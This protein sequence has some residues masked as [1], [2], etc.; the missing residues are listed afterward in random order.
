MSNPHTVTIKEGYLKIAFLLSAAHYHPVV[1]DGRIEAN[2]TV[3]L[4]IL[5][6][7]LYIHCKTFCFTCA[8]IKIKTNKNITLISEISF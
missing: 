6:E 4:L 1:E 8:Q 5:S 3:A 2:R 7:P